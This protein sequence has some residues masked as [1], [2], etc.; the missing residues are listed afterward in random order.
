MKQA[1]F[2]FKMVINTLEIK[3]RISLKVKEYI[4]LVTE[5]HI[6]ENG[7]KTI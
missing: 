4:F 5:L 2:T 7:I 3:I 1:L 6:K